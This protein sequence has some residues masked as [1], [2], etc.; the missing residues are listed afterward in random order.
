MLTRIADYQ[1]KMLAIRSKLRG[2]LTYPAAILAVAVAVTIL[3]LVLVVPAFEN[4]FSSF[5]AA[6]PWPTRL[7]ID[8]SAFIRD[9]GFIIAMIVVALV[10]GILHQWRQN[11]GWQQATDRWQLDLPVV[12]SLLRRC[13]LY[14]SPSPRD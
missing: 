5:G 3:M 6:L 2:A 1:E 4:S 10:T 9:N 11:P 14:T 13:L 12:G 7:I 8:G